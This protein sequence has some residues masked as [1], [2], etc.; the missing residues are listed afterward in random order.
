MDSKINIILA[1]LE[2]HNS[3]HKMADAKAYVVLVILGFIGWQVMNIIS[4]IVS[5]L[6]KLSQF[7]IV[8]VVLSIIVLVI[9]YIISLIFAIKTL[10]SITGS[11]KGN[12]FEQ[13]MYD[14]H[15]NLKITYYKF[16]DVKWAVWSMIIALFTFIILYGFYKFYK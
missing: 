2:K 8:L 6:N 1:Y 10:F 14:F 9:S 13:M 11:T 7:S 16:K 15:T 4:G 5:F 3:L 12:I